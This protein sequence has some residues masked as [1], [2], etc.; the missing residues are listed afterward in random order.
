[1]SIVIITGSPESG[2]TLTANA[3]R[4]DA[5]SRG[6]GCLLIDDTQ[7]GEAIP[8][9]EK[10]IAGVPFDPKTPISE[11]PWKEDPL[12]IAVGSGKDRLD[13]IEALLP[14]FKAA[15]GPVYTVDTGK[16]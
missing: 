10:I 14:G 15:M 6:R 11:I 13:E 4:N 1:M 7:D 3:L 16:D 8:L 2:K 12:I 5:I 9:L